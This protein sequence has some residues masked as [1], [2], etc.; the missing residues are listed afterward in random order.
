MSPLLSFRL[1]V[2]WG[3]AMAMGGNFVARWQKFA[4]RAVSPVCG[5]AGS[6][7]LLKYMR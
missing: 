3:A 2:Q 6:I 7:K 4:A 5:G 1:A